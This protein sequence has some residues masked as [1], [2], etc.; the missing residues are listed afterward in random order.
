MIIVPKYVQ[1]AE[2]DEPPGKTV[3]EVDRYQGFS[4]TE[5]DAELDRRLKQM[6]ELG[7]D[8]ADGTAATVQSQV[9]RIKRELDRRTRAR[10]PS[11]R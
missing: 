6:H 8:S 4:D 10:H 1:W 5:L 11:T 9:E 2:G 7:H 3:D